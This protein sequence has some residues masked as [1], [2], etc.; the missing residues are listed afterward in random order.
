L[1]LAK[2]RGESG[3]FEEI[4]IFFKM[5]MTKNKEQKAENALHRQEAMLVDWLKSER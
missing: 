3:V 2:R 5:P 1:D 4:S